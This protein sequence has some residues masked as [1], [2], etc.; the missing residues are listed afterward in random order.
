[1]VENNNRRFMYLERKGKISIARSESTIEQAVLSALYTRL[2]YEPSS[3][4]AN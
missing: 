3:A 4:D 2:Q 1:M